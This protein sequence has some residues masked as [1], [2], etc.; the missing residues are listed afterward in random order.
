MSKASVS[1]FM[2]EGFTLSK[3]VRGRECEMDRTIIP[4]AYAARH[5]II[6]LRVKIGD[7]TVVSV[8]T[9]KYND[10]VSSGGLIGRCSL[11][12]SEDLLE[13]G[14]VKLARLRRDLIHSLCEN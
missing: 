9:R 1:E 7:V 8:Q 2:N 13:S 11:E 10:C 5:G 12:S 14:L 3:M 6:T 4:E